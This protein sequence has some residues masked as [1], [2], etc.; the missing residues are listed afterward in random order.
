MLTKKKRL[1][2]HLTKTQDHTWSMIWLATVMI[3]LSKSPSLSL[4]SLSTKE[5]TSG[6]CQNHHPC[7]CHP[8]QRGR[9]HKV[10][11]KITIL[12]LVILV[13]EGENIR[14]LSTLQQYLTQ[15]SSS[16]HQN[17]FCQRGGQH[18]VFV[19]IITNVI[20][21]IT[22]PPKLFLSTRETTSGL[23]Q[24]YWTRTTRTTPSDRQNHPCRL[25]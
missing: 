17:F 12:V 2:N 24:Q 8:C 23:C 25:S 4:S 18:S 16:N 15:T 1:V 5:T 13:N 20:I 6:L 9:Q 21:N 19:G 22:K 7:P 10:F 14:S 3:S 11:V